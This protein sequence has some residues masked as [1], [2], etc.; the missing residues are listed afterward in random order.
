MLLR[1]LK[2]NISFVALEEH[3]ASEVIGWRYEEPYDIYDYRNRNAN[4]IISYLSDPLNGFFAVLNQEIFIG[5]RS[6]GED[7]RVF[8]GDYDNNYLDTGG[9]LRP[10]LTGQGLGSHILQKGIEFGR[11]EYAK[12][13]FRTTVAKFNIR[14]QKVCKNV[15]FCINHEFDRPSDGER[16][17]VFTI[18]Y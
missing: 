3:H 8:G 14:A 18:D 4:E 9:G 6:F 16:F 1:S 12:T 10:D 11:Q 2:M 17:I 15:G 5:F 13:A 7:G